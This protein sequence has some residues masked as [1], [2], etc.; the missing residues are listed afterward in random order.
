MTYMIYIYTVIC[1]CVLP[2]GVSLL[3]GHYF[4]LE[5]SQRLRW[6]LGTRGDRCRVTAVNALGPVTKRERLRRGGRLPGEV[7][8]GSEAL[9]VNIL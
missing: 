5:P 4:L 2:I 8:L 9:R 7:R 6:L 3:S 1:I